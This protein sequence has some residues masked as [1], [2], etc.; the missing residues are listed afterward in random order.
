M[1][2][3]DNYSNGYIFFSKTKA[4]VYPITI[5]KQGK[6][7]AVAVDIDQVKSIYRKIILVYIDGVLNLGL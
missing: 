7:N 6:E 3:Y 1:E 4:H 5:R 2:I